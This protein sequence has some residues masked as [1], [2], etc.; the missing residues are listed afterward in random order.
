MIEAIDLLSA[1]V[2]GGDTF[3]CVVIGGEPAGLSAAIHLRWHGRSVRLV[4]S[5][6]SRA[7]RIARALNVAGYPDG[8][9]DGHLLERLRQHRRA[10]DG[11]VTYDSV[12]ER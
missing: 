2:I 4:D 5:S 10:A 12:D 7:Q 1:S 6:A 3:D 11:H 8:V 9:V